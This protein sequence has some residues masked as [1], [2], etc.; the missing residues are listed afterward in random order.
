[1]SES[2]SSFAFSF[3]VATT[4][5]PSYPTLPFLPSPPLPLTLPST[6]SLARTRCRS[7]AGAVGLV[8]IRL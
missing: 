3:V 1:M 6:P 2:E 5:L 8:F 7:R 4:S